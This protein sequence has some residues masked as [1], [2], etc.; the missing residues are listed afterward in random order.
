MAAF[1]SCFSRPLG[2]KPDAGRICLLRACC[3]AAGMAVLAANTHAATM[4]PKQVEYKASVNEDPAAKVCQ[5]GLAMR[6]T[7]AGGGVNFQLI[8]AQMKQGGVLA[9]PLVTAFTVDSPS[10]QFTSRFSRQAK[11]ASVAFVSE[12]YNSVALPKSAPFQDGSVAASTLDFE[13]GRELITAVLRAD[14]E[15]SFTRADSSTVESYRVGSPPPADVLSQFSTCVG[16]LA[17]S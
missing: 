13:E 10:L 4:V 1:A 9:G 7:P 5:L 3:V 6:N 15:L 17:S 2:R 12:R 16:S 11:L 14:Y 8:V